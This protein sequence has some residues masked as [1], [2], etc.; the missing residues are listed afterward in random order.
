MRLAVFDRRPF[1]T[2]SGMHISRLAEQ[3]GIAI[4]I[5]PPSTPLSRRIG[6]DPFSELT[7]LAEI[8][9]GM[10]GFAGVAAAVLLGQSYKRDDQLRFISLFVGS[11]CV[12][13]LAYVPV[14]LRE[15]G[16]AGM[17]LWRVSSIIFFVVS[18]SVFPI[19]NTIRR[20]R[21]TFEKLPPK[22]AFFPLWTFWALGPVLQ[23]LNAIGWPAEPGPVPYMI[24][25]LS[26][27]LA[28]AELFGIIVLLR[29]RPTTTRGAETGPVVNSSASPRD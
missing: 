7:S 9:V 1:S 15:A 22:W 18:S 23:I 24:G 29:P 14:V 11:V 2:G 4:A 10:A 27:L 25:L 5:R 13:F 21:H 6:V 20:E 28:A 8:G 17:T 16:I 12:I 26:W 19:G 3:T